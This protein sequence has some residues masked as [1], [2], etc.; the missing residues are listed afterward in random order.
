MVW[1]L[2]DAAAFVINLQFVFFL[3][4]STVEFTPAVCNRQETRKPKQLL[5]VENRLQIRTMKTSAGSSHTILG[6]FLSTFWNPFRE[7]VA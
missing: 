5:T 6:L 1:P 7:L 2:M 3:F 4:L